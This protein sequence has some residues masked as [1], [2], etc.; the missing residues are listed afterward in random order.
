M[1]GKLPFSKKFISSNTK[2]NIIPILQS[3]ILPTIIVSNLLSET[4]KCPQTFIVNQ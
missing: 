4:M 3:M 2:F 1:F